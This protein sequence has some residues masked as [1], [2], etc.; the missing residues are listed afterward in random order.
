MDCII[1][2]NEEA[3]KQLDEITVEQWTYSH[4]G[5]HRH[6]ARTTN[7]SECFNGVLKGTRSLP[8]TALVKLTFFKLVSYFDDRCAKI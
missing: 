5:G 6:G 4:D 7:L 3:S 1:K 2:Y 8:I